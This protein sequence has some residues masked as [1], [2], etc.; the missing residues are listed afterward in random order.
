MTEVV[1]RIEDLAEVRT[2]LLD[3]AQR[4][5]TSTHSL[6]RA[7]RWRSDGLRFDPQMWS[8]MAE[9]GWLGM[10]LPEA[11]G[12]FGLDL[13]AIASLAAQLGAALLPEPFVGCAVAPAALL[14][15]A[16]ASNVRDTLAQGLSDGSRVLAIAWQA[17][18]GEVD[19]TWAG[20]T[21]SAHVN[22][23]VLEGMRVAV[24]GAA[25]QWLVAAYQDGQPRVVLVD[26]DAAGVRRETHPLADGSAMDTLHF[27]G[28]R[29]AASAVLL[30]GE[31]A[32]GA[33]TAALDEARVV[34]AAHLAGLAEAALSMT[35]EYLTQ[36]AQFGQPI[37]N[38]QAIRHRLVDLDL[39]KRLAFAAWRKACA[40]HAE[41]DLAPEAF[42]VAASA[43][44]ARC[45]D[46][47]MLVGRS[48]VQMHGAIGYT[49]EAD[50][51]LFVDAALKHASA[52]GNAQAHR[53]RLA[54]LTFERQLE[55]GAASLV[56]AAPPAEP[57]GPQPTTPEAWAALSDDDF[58]LHL[59]AW[60]SA[61]YPEEWRKPIVLRLRGQSERDW[62]ATLYRHGL[63]A[64]AISRAMGGMGLSL[65]KQLIYK[66]VFDAHGVAR[67]LDMAST[68]L[69]P[70]L[71]RY[72]SDEQ[73]ARYLPP[74]LRGDDVWCQGYSEPGAGSDLA[75]LRTSAVRKGDVFVVNGQKTWTSHA[76]NAS[77][78]F[79]LVRTGQ[80][81]RKQQGISMLLVDLQTPGITIRP[82][83]NM[84]GDDEFCEVFFD[85]V[86]VP[87]EQ[88]LGQ[89]DEGWNVAKSLLGVERL[90]NGSPALGQQA[91]D[92]L[93]QMLAAAPD[94]RAAAL[95]D[96]RL[97]RL[98]CDLHDAHALYEEVCAAAVAG[99][100]LDAEY[101]VI[102]V[103]STEL[104]QR[105]VDLTM[106]LA[107]ERSGTQGAQPFGTD[108]VDLH[109]LYMISRPGTIYGGA[110]EVQRDILARALLGA[111][112]SGK[113]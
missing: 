110:N 60:L 2:M 88:L 13:S 54:A 26:A 4:F 44:K 70:I 77:R 35:S 57:A 20:A 3:G 7:R 95:T 9:C 24:E 71:I 37:A 67:V 18:Y 107:G 102:K 109:R 6:Q 82:I 80:Y 16:P 92:Y 38:F 90:V 55:A 42:A 53:R 19:P 47:A 79:M 87:T 52:F 86:E 11:L 84:A 21:L 76:N 34:M 51:G 93:L 39:Q 74:I 66:K 105:M 40:L 30:G 15:A 94:M 5:L 58:A 14:A 96:D 65:Q 106:D 22:G 28:V 25:D 75:G 103:M 101:S 12:G 45:S 8:S 63:R 36:R 56:R 81:A 112:P 23:F 73:K 33:L 48:A 111:P 31:E 104:F 68:L 100:P 59:Q 99:Q 113:R 1:S 61:H 72:G 43:A 29:I 32:R 41:V 64:P 49:Q 17:Q 62:L 85:N 50:I 46:V 27:S 98:A 91:F 97:P 10:R 89:V 78:I 83:V 69:A 108:N